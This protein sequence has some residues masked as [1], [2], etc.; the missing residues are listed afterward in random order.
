MA[1]YSEGPKSNITKTTIVIR[2]A[3]TSGGRFRFYFKDKAGSAL[4]LN[5]YWFT[6]YINIGDDYKVVA[7]IIANA[8]NQVFAYPEVLL[9]YQDP[10]DEDTWLK[11]WPEEYDNSIM[12][13]DPLI[14]L[15][16]DIIG[17]KAVIDFYTIGA[18]FQY[19]EKNDVTGTYGSTYNT[20]EVSVAM[21]PDE[22]LEG[23]GS[24]MITSD[25]T[26]YISIPGKITSHRSNVEDDY[27]SLNFMV[28]SWLVGDMSSTKED[29]GSQAPYFKI[30]LFTND[31]ISIIA[32]R[33]NNGQTA[34]TAK[35]IAC[36]PLV[37]QI[38][39][40]FNRVAAKTGLFETDSFNVVVK[41]T[42]TLIEVGICT[43]SDSIQHQISCFSNGAPET[44]IRV[45]C[46]SYFINDNV[47]EL[48]SYYDMYGIDKPSS[49]Q[50][51]A[52]Y[53]PLA[54]GFKF[55]LDY[56]TEYSEQ[57]ASSIDVTPIPGQSSA[58][59]IGIDAT[60]CLR[61][62]T[63]G[64]IR[65]DNSNIW[66]FHIPWQDQ[67]TNQGIIY[68]GTSNWGWIKFMKAILGTFQ[69][70]SGPYRLIMMTIPSSAQMQYFPTR[71]GKYQYADGTYVLIAGWED[72]CY[73]M[74]ENFTYS[75]SEEMFNAI[76]YNLK[77]KR[78]APLMVN[79]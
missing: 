6:D 25:Y 33:I 55:S 11:G 18:R 60:G 46:N 50:V 34:T 73:V 22:T 35:P 71:D 77:L 74:V 30:P 45:I 15:S 49:G 44:I 61:D 69:M 58:K 24:L 7:G 28:D 27:M 38:N 66:M 62:I 53:K 70:T 4:F 64:G 12:Y 5:R 29:L 9:P 68:T 76:Q 78:V 14:T 8:A 23:F 59:A 26:T 16:E 1:E 52:T 65:V 54:F 40:Y 47:F 36:Y 32:E 3:A 67:G 37:Y 21:M 2:G 48:R 72:M 42:S 57:E 13:K 39:D 17:G 79:R 41:Y 31:T 43:V 63:L 20:S 10:P 51:S 56:I 19:V 75:R